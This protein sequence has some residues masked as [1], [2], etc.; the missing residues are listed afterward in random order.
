MEDPRDF[1]LVREKIRDRS[2]Y[3][4]FCKEW[5]R[6]DRARREK[7]ARCS[8]KPIL[9]K[10]SQSKPSMTQRPELPREGQNLTTTTAQQENPVKIRLCAQCQRLHHLM[11]D[12]R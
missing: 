1:S 3:I 8:R 6:A 9:S 4:N 5:E 10:S 7:M 11:I 12:S 2:S